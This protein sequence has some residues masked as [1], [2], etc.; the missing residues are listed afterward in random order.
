MD[1]N[2]F[3]IFKVGNEKFGIRIT[4]VQE[5][6]K[7]QEVTTLPES[8]QFIKGIIELRGEVI[9]IV[10]LGERLGLTKDNNDG[11]V[12]VVE[13]NGVKAGLIVDDA[14]DVIQIDENMIKKPK[15]NMAGIKTEYLSGVAKLDEELIVLLDFDRLFS[16]EQ[17]VQIEQAAKENN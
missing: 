1:T 6:I 15:G 11:R 5:I 7:P 14:S 13:I 2:Q 12:L 10:N 4:E 17:Q 9:V 3:I 8:A 16:D